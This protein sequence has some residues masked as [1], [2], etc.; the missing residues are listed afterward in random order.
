MKDAF[1]LFD[2]KPGCI[3]YLALSNI[4]YVFMYK[5]IYIYKYN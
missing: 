3:K 1:F 2:S 4:N 5:E